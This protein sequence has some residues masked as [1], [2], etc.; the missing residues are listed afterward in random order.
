VSRYLAATLT[1][2][3]LLWFLLLLVAP[4]A[5]ARGPALALPAAWLYEAAGRI[6]HQRPER[7]FTIAGVQQ[8]VCA[9]C[10]GLYAAGALGAALAWTTMGGVRR[11]P[12]R[13]RMILVLCAAPTA[14]TF[15]L[16]F[17]GLAHPSSAVRAVAALPL[18]LFAGFLVVRLLRDERQHAS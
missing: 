9:R 10:A 11:R 16:E 8:P 3:A 7:S 15:G 1:A 18:G 5:I 12:S 14:I 2:G 13:D 17:A 4:V 6:C